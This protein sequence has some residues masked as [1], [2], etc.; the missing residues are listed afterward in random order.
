[1]SSH[2]RGEALTGPLNGLSGLGIPVD[3]DVALVLD[4]MVNTNMTISIQARKGMQQKIHR[5]QCVKGL[6]KLIN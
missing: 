5:R 1:M 2:R 3:T 4:E 6:I